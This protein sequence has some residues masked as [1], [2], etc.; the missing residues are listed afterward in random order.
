MAYRVNKPAGLFAAA[1]CAALMLLSA[2]GDDGSTDNAPG[3]NAP[4]ATNAGG[5]STPTATFA[6]SGAGY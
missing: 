4:V 6:N 5:A 2:C 1:A 3:S